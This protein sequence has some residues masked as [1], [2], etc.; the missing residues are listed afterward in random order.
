MVNN[1]IEGDVSI[2]M[3]AI[4]LG[5]EAVVKSICDLVQSSGCAGRIIVEVTE[6]AMMVNYDVIKQCVNFLK[7]AG[8]RIAIDDFGAGFSSFRNVIELPVDVIKVDGS[9]ITGIECDRKKHALV[10]GLRMMAADM[11]IKIV[12]ERI[13]NQ[14]QLDICKSIGIDYGQGFYLAVPS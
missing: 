8:V 6:T 2:N 9:F 5:S 3:S 12:A 13:E 4:T 11:N 14:A 1:A 10:S 7:A